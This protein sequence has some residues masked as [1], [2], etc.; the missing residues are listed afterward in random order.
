MEKLDRPHFI[1]STVHPARAPFGRSIPLYLGFLSKR[2]RWTLRRREEACG[3]RLDGLLSR[4]AF[5]TEA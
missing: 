5:G 2:G 1:L 3:Y 4:Y